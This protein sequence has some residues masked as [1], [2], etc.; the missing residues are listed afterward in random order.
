MT[1]ENKKLLMNGL[2]ALVL[3]VMSSL[4][5]QL[6]NCSAGIATKGDLVQATAEIKQELAKC[7]QRSE[8]GPTPDPERKLPPVYRR[9]EALEIDHAAMASRHA[10]D[11]REHVAF[12]VGFWRL[13]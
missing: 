10:L 2:A 11:E 6:S 3:I 8:L 5:T 12:T 13:V 7:V 4:G 9:I 1:E